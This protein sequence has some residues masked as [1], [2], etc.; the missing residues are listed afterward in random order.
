MP[1]VEVNGQ[2]IEF[3]DDMQPDAIKD[4]LRAKFPVANDSQRA[5]SFMGRLG[6]DYERRTGQIG[7][8][9][10]QAVRGDISK[11]EALGRS[12]LKMAQMLPDTAGNV[13]STL[14]PDFIEK[15]IVEQIGNATSY[16]ADTRAGRTAVGAVNDFNQQYP[17]TSGRIGSAFDA[18]NLLLPFKKVGG[19]NAI[20]AT[21][22][23]TGAVADKTVGAAGR[24]AVNAV[25]PSAED[26][27]IDVASTARRFDIP[28]S[29]D[30]VSGSRALKTAQKVSQDLPFSGQQRF[31]ETQMRAL[32]KALFKTVGVEADMFNAKTMNKAFSKVGG[33][34]DNI[35]K[36]KK[37]NIGGNFIEDLAK[38]S[39]DVRSQYGDEAF[40][41]FQREAQRVVN[42]FSGDEISG[43][44]ISRQRSRINALARK[45]APGQKEALL[46]LEASIVD[47]ITSGDPITQSA[48][49]QAK[50]RYKNLIVLEPIANKAKGGM[51]SPSLLNNRV[52]QVYKRA[53]TIGQSGDIGDLARVGSELLPELGGSDTQSKLFY[54]IGA[55]GTGLANAPAT[56][57]GLGANRVLQS[58]INRNQG[59]IDKSIMKAIRKMPPAEAKVALERLR[60][61]T[62]AIEST[63]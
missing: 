41:A 60:G 9:A 42:D 14:T 12:G 28:L 46:D 6:Q 3:P 33:E 55:T 58:G 40:N 38:T 63:R 23:A 7:D 52:A 44:L 31:R 35:T 17:V 19:Q 15:P 21:T 5:D 32:N 39:E 54:A 4:V 49:T 18:V 57:V 45:A 13:I 1:I 47:G 30:Q 36:G 43:E 53:H 62:K 22:K 61:A 2:E 56:A 20:T 59:I 34:F 27:L 37:F 8:L 50:Q 26:G 10:E 11:T 16:L 24:A 25:I 48:L 29:L 51:I